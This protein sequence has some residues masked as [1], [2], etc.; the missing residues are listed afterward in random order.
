[1][2]DEQRTR[3]EPDRTPDGEP[4]H[5]GGMPGDGVGR[6]EEPGETGVHPFS[7]STGDMPMRTAGGW[8]RSGYEES[9]GSEVNPEAGGGAEGAGGAGVGVGREHQA[10]VDE[11]ASRDV[12]I[13]RNL[14]E[15]GMGGTSV[16]TPPEEPTG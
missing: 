6:R 1:M 4:Q 14:G 9:G 12:D 10:D 11:A 5:R 2:T 7:E 8:G 13:Q 3:E 16:R 15:S